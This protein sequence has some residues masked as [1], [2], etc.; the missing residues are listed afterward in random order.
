MRDWTK[1]IP[2]KISRKILFFVSY[3]FYLNTCNGFAH[4]IG[5]E[6]SNPTPLFLSPCPPSSFSLSRRRR[7]RKRRLPT[8]LR[9]ISCVR[10][11]GKRK[12]YAEAP[13]PPPNGVAIQEK[14]FGQG[15]EKKMIF[16]LTCHPWNKEDL[17]LQGRVKKSKATNIFI[18]LAF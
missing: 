2:F 5:T 12:K 8:A 18:R 17:A 4:N 6:M 10:I 1:R 7:R 11:G 3:K 13:L 15:R 9:K 14:R 16:F